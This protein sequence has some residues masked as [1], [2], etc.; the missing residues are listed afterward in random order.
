MRIVLLTLAL[1]SAHG[2]SL[3]QTSIGD[4]AA[5]QARAL[6]A[7]ARRALAR[8]LEAP[9]APASAPGTPIPV[10]PAVATGRN[11]VDRLEP[12]AEPTLAVRGVAQLRS[13]RFAEVSTDTGSWMLGEGD[14]VPGTAWR[15]AAIDVDQVR[16]SRP[17]GN[18]RKPELR[19]YLLRG[20]R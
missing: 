8:T 16:L 12:K 19:T 13:R 2:L 7:E 4:F 15:V 1:L 14:A 18:P 5:A 11:A 17:T 3:A 20:V 6:D 9:S 10:V